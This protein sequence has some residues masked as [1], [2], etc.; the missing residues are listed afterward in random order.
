MICVSLTLPMIRFIILLIH[1]QRV[2][3]VR[4]FDFFLL[5]MMKTICSISRQPI[6]VYQP[7][8]F[9]LQIVP[10]MILYVVNYY[11]GMQGTASRER[12]ERMAVMV[13]RDRTVP[14]V[15]QPAQTES[16]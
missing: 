4:I 2:L 10:I 12:K 15:R 14:L 11:R 3:Y 8:L 5:L 13:D 9:I 16:L 1:C 7:M 6:M